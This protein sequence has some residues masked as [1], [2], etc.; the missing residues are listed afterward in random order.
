M[1]QKSNYVPLKA[2]VRQARRDAAMTQSELAYEMGVTVRAVQAWELG[3]SEPAL[4]RRRRLARVTGKP[5]EWFNDM[6][7]PGLAAAARDGDAA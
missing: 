1:I 4:S 3:E 5:L 7:D 2:R 6:H